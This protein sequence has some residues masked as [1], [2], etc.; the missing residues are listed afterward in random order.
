MAVEGELPLAGRRG[1][2]FRVLL[3]Q[4]K[5]LLPPPLLLLLLL[6]ALCIGSSLVVGGDG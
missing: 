4:L 6:V 5:L 1:E 2:L 3:L